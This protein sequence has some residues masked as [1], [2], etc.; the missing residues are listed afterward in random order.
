MCTLVLSRFPKMDWPLIIAANRDEMGGRAWQ[1]PARHWPDRA[2]VVGGLD[3]VAQGSWLALNQFGVVAAILNRIG[4]LGPQDGKRS[5]GELV[6][7]ALDHADAIDA[8][9]ALMELDGRAYRGFNMLVADNRDAFWIRKGVVS[10]RVQVVP[11]N[12]G[13]HILTAVDLDDDSSP[14][15]ATYLP[16][17]R[18]ATRPNPTLDD[19]T[20][21]AQLM[22]DT[23]ETGRGNEVASLCFTL[24]SGFGTVSSSLLALPGVENP[25]PPVWH[26]ASGRPDRAPFEPVPL[27]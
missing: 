5:R 19:W 15:V 1:P 23:G 4:T 9:R 21:W 16:R 14:R 13:V 11:I 3:E 12:E 10:D 6:L 8:A 24:P 18:Q 27:G 7:E 20:A 25:H 26:F 17:F 22:G 2:D